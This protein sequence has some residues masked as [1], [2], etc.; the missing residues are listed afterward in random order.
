MI[1]NIL[2]I[3]A[4]IGILLGLSKLLKAENFDLDNE[5]DEL[6][7]CSSCGKYLQKGLAINSPRGLFC[8]KT[9]P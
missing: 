7:K 3:L 9:K 2:F 5:N 1:L 8:K 6:I 4:F